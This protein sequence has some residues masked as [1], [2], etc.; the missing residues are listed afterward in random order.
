MTTAGQCQH[1]WEEVITPSEVSGLPDE[2]YQRCKICETTKKEVN[3]III[4]TN[5]IDPWY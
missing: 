5:P 3:G 4:T 1:E 2:V